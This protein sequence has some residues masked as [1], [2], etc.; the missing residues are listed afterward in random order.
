MGR[1]AIVIVQRKNIVDHDRGN[2]GSVKIWDGGRRKSSVHYRHRH[3]TISLNVEFH[4]TSKFIQH[5]NNMALGLIICDV[6]ILKR[7]LFQ[8]I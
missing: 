8:T 4:I 1:Q 7:H 2:I 3:Y 6:L 5:K